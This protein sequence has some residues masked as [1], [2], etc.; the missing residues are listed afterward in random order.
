MA[1]P[2]QT[3][4]DIL[5][6]PRDATAADIGQAYE[7]RKAELQAAPNP[8][9]N[10]LNLASE[11]HQVLRDPRRRAAYDTSLVAAEA[12]AA[13][14]VQAQ[15]DIVIEP[16]DTA[17]AASKR[18]WVPIAAGIAI[19]I[20]A[21]FIFMRPARLPPP[22]ATAP[23]AEAEAPKPVAPA[24]APPKPR[25]G[26]EVMADAVTS[27]GQLMSYSMSGQAIPLGIATSTEPGTMITTCH[28]IP[29]GAKLVVRVGQQSHPADLLITD[30][31]LDLCKLQVS[32]FQVPPVKVSTEEPKAGDRIFAMGV[33]AKGDFAVTEGTV[34]Q[35]LNTTEGK[36][37]ELSM[38]VGQYSSGGGV[39]DAYGRL[40]GISTFQH[41]SG[42]SIAIPAADIAKMRSR[43]AAK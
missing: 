39:F 25:S 3:L 2:K 43:G 18:P 41:R 23:Q 36:L 17:P 37:I 22:P 12:R 11:A 40:I 16:D 1:Q 9:A 38:P 14:G 15:P 13:A 26:V 7:R 6:V 20:A 34:K 19:V 10:A 32:N 35:L 42:L 24:P 8:D 21:L 4:Y 31:A 5:G 30:E 33:N 28:G 27:G 29:G